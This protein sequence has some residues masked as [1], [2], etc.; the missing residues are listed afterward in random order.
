MT[1]QQALHD[2]FGLES[3]RPGQVEVVEAQLA[4][5]DVLSVAP[6]GSGKSISYWVPALVGE[7]LTV[8]VSPL[9]ALMKDQVDR[10]RELRVKAAFINSSLS[11]PDQQE[12]LRVARLGGFQLLYVAPERLSRPGFL[13]RLAETKITRFVVDEAHCISSWGH[14]FRP[15]YRFL[16]RDRKSTRLNSSHRH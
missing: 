16:G 4:G 1:P 12:A 11:R 13:D 5:R 15:D 3:F 10:L 9:I 2:V 6:T 8:V 14:D 7:G